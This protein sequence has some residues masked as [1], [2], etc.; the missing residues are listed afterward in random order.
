LSAP[1]LCE[2]GEGVDSS[3]WHL[4]PDV[5]AHRD[6]LDEDVAATAPSGAEAD[7]G[8]AAPQWGNSGGGFD[9]GSGIALPPVALVAW[10]DA[11]ASP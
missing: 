1:S 2:S 10:E 9:G 8:T 5:D 11:E 4:L 6:F 3:L 7:A